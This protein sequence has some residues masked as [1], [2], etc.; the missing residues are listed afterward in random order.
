MIASVAAYRDGGG[1]LDELLAV[2]D[3]NRNLMST[4]LA[5]RLPG[6]VY[7]PPEAG[8]LGW[9]DCRALGLP[10]EPVDRFL[11]RGR[12]ALTAGLRFGSQGSGHVRVTMATSREILAEIVERMRAALA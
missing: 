4:L 9:L 12:V 2:L 3:R 5:E 1:W 11:E 6:I 10:Q 8:Y 7:R